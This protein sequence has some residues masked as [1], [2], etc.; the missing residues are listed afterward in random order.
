MADPKNYGTRVMK[1][2]P[3]AGREGFDYTDSIR[4]IGRQMATYGY[5]AEPD[6]RI[7]ALD[8][9]EDRRALSSQ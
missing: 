7:L 1:F 3:P 9:K 5:L 4:H 8:V 6:S 2:T